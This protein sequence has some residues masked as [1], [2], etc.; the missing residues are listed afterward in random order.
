MTDVVKV[1]EGNPQEEAIGRAAEVIRG[2]GLVAFPTETVY[3][4]GADAMNERAIRKIFEAKGR[5]ADNPL[6][7]HV[8][9]RNEVERVAEEVSDKAWRLINDFWPG[10]LTLVLKRK[11]AVPASVSAG[12]P[13]VAVR[14]PGNAIAISLIRRAGTP[15]AAPSANRSGRPSPTSAAHV[16][17]DLDGQID[18]I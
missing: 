6:I 9:H 17:D 18:M 4:L 7:I 5:P 11:G 15:I 10:P 3:G 12:L 2:G 14:M 13:T 16:L 8:G 1:D